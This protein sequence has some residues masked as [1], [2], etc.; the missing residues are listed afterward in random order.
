M[1]LARESQ[2]F[3]RALLTCSNISADRSPYISWWGSQ[4]RAHSL[5]RGPSKGFS[6]HLWFRALGGSFPLLSPRLTG[7]SRAGVGVG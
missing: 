1:A 2:V 3:Q 7:A 6:P 4:A 5:G